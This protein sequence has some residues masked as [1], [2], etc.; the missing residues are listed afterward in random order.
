MGGRLGG[1]LGSEGGGGPSCPQPQ[2]ASPYTSSGPQKGNR[3][4][5]PWFPGLTQAGPGTAGQ[6]SLQTPQ[7]Q[8]WVPILALRLVKRV[9]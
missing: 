9:T 8:A 6:E 5:R 7:S 2:Q 3:P 1:R 4:L